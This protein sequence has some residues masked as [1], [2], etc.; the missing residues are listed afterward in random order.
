MSKMAAEDQFREVTWE[1]VTVGISSCLLGN[2][3]RYDGRDALD[4]YITETLAKYFNWAPVCP[5]TGYGLPVP[6]EAMRLQGSPASPR[7]VTVHTGVDHTEGMLAWARQKMPELEK[8]ELCGF[9]FKSK[10]PSSGMS[11]V[12]VYSDTGAPTKK[13]IGIFAGAFMRHFPL[14]PVIDDERLHDPLL[15][16][17]FVEKVFAYGHRHTY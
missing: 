9:I 10:S 7:L 17:S 4:S 15:R 14:L 13:G 16:K 6:R 3:V 2:K 12:K 1:K 11:G 5:E 8:E